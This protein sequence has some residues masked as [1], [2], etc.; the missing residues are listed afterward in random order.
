MDD[1]YTSVIVPAAG[2]GSR[3]QTDINKQ[4]LELDGKP[5]IVHTILALDQCQLFGEI[6]IVA[7]EIEIEIFKKKLNEN[8][9]VTPMK[10]VKGGNS[11][12]DSVYNG[13]QEVS[14]HSKF[15]AVHDGA[16]P[17]VNNH[18]LKRMMDEVYIKGAVIAAVPSIDTVKRVNERNEIEETLD[19]GQ[20]WNAQTP[21]VFRCDVLKAAYEKARMENF[22]GTDDSSLVEWMGIKVYPVM[23]SYNNIKITTAK[24]L[25]LGEMILKER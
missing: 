19:R 4:L 14:K 7:K 24:D 23:G 10:F 18:L 5:I 3:M 8:Q 25:V 11:R 9:I 20:L 17:F 6:I 13:I 15:I 22:Q 1:K 2:S 12:Q 21:Q 16:R